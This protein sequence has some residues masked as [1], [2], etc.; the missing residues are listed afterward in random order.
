[1]GVIKKEEA[2]YLTVLTTSTSKE[3]PKWCVMV[4]KSI[5]KK[6]P[7]LVCKKVTK[8]NRKKPKKN[9]SQNQTPKLSPN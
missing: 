2:C 1:M 9:S 6:L 5:K 8:P 4:T 7:N 3:P